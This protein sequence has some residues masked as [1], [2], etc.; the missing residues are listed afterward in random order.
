[1]RNR[2]RLKASR[3]YLA[4]SVVGILLFVGNLILGKVEIA[5]K[6]DTLVHLEGVPEFLLLLASVILFVASTLLKE[7]AQDEDNH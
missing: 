1:M 7:R 5:Y 4:A 2:D 3:Y 6:I